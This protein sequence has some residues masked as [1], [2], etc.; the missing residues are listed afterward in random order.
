MADWGRIAAGVL[1]G[2]ASE[3]M[4]ALSKTG[5]SSAGVTIAADPYGET[6]TKYLDWLNGQI[7]QNG[8]TYTGQVVAP[9][10][11]QENQS[12]QTLN[13]YANR[14][15]PSTFTAAKKQVEDTL[16]GNFDPTKSAYYQG[17]KAEAA[18]N[19]ADTQSNIADQAS[20]KGA[21]WTGARAKLQSDAATDTG[22]ALNTLLGQ[23]AN[24]ERN[25]QMQAIP[26]AQSLAETEDNQP[27]KTTAALQEFGGLERE[28]QNATNQAAY[29]QWYNSN[30]TYPLQIAQLAAGTQQA[31]LYAQTGY[32]PSILQQLIS[33]FSG[34]FGK[35]AGTSIGTK[36]FG[37][38]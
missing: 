31:P 13:Q 8:K 29:D 34:G 30:I 11:G 21:F 28:N 32:T 9:L 37:G 35:S 2:G 16:G 22:L 27:L 12:L 25:R 14:T 23:L 7:G 10:T 38:Q 33:A 6:R 4:R 20:G 3:A 24:E 18:N 1:T 26:Y 15:T 36:L 19:L 5:E 17:V